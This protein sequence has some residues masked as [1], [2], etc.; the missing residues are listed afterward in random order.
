M[1]RVGSMLQPFTTPR[2]EREPRTASEAALLQDEA[3]YASLCDALERNGIYAHRYGLGRWF[4]ST[5][6]DDAIVEETLERV[7]RAVGELAYQRLTAMACDGSSQGLVHS[8][9]TSTFP[10][11]HLHAASPATC[12]SMRPPTGT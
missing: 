11:L 8:L 6:H 4:V 2:P 10:L 1:R 7:R 3:R 5:A 12:R 9:P